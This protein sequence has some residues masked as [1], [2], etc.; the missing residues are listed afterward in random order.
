MVA[1]IIVLF[2]IFFACCA[3]VRS[4]NMM[5][6]LNLRLLEVNLEI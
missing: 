5:S 4:V 1:V 3:R 2:L 6:I